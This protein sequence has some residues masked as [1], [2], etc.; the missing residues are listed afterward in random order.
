MID[1]GFAV[2]EKIGKV[3]KAILDR[4]NNKLR[5]KTTANQWRNSESVTTWFKAIT[6]KNKH[7]FISFDIVDFY[8]SI[9]ENLLNEAINWAR[10]EI[11]ISDNETDTIAAA[12]KSLLFHKNKPWVKRDNNNMFDVTMG[13]ND[14]AEVCELV[15]LCIIHKASDIFGVENIGLYRDDGLILEIPPAGYQKEERKT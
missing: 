12:R 3:S 11:S 6:D 14:G 13:S 5:S 15:G 4:I 2:E 10:S 8:P 7:S 1:R 9:S